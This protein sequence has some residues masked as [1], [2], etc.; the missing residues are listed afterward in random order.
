MTT[1]TEWDLYNRWLGLDRENDRENT[2][3][4]AVE[5]LL[6]NL[7]SNPSYQSGALRN[8]EKQPI[9]ATR[10]SMKKC[11]ITVVPG[12]TMNVGDLISVFDE[13]WLCMEL[14]TDE[15]GITYGELWMCNH[16]FTFQNKTPAIISKHGIID[17]GS[18]SKG[19]DKAIM[20]TENKYNCYLPHDQETEGLYV[21]KR[22]AISV[23]RDASGDRVLEV[24][25]ITWIDTKSG[26]YGRGSHLMSFCLENDVYNPEKD[27]LEKFICDYI[28]DTSVGA[29]DRNSEEKT[30]E[31][32]V[33][34]GKDTIR[35]GTG[36]T[37]TAAIEDGASGGENI[38]E[39]LQWGLL[40]DLTGVE[41]IANGAKCILR[42]PLD[43]IL[44]GDTITLVCKDKTGRLAAGNKEVV[45]IPIG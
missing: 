20:V 2:I 7:E 32:I 18:Y 36:R 45:V 17:D 29:A 30:S 24:G 1:N 35:I 23:T 33:I 14:Y 37:Y 31:T 40:D 26:N 13:V 42:L 6:S 41:V 22:L 3:S 5:G 4:E 12:D 25:K 19:G 15:Y 9:L 39:D 11:N 38:N 34:Q 27:N 10:K 44:V 21:D 28:A 8:G 16:V 43:D